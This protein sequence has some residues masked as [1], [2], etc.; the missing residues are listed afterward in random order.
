MYHHQRHALQVLVA[1]GWGGVVVI[2]DRLDAPLANI[3]EANL[4]EKQC[5]GVEVGGP[6]RPVLVL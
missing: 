6:A 2:H 3:L 5:C 1:L 4:W